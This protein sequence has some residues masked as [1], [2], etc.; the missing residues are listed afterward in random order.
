MRL[1][2]AEEV[3]VG[4]SEKFMDMLVDRTVKILDNEPIDIYV[5]P[6]YL[7]DEIADRYDELWTEER[8]DLVIAALLRNEIA[9]EIND[10]RRIPSPAFIKRAKEQGIKFTFG[11]NN[12]GPDDLGNLEY[13]LEMIE[14]CGLRP[15]DIW[16]P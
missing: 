15:D 5:N 9:L 10:R 12:G 6:T 8:M 1:W 11:T 16:R 13:C 4:D 7:P 14:E 2:I 3:E